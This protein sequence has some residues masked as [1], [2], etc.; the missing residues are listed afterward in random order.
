M[1][2]EDGCH[3]R[4]DT[5]MP[6]T[7]LKG[8]EGRGIRFITTICYN[9]LPVFRNEQAAGLVTKQLGETASI[10]G[11][12]IAAYVVMPTHMHGLFGF[13]DVK[14]MPEFML[15]FKSLSSR[16]IKELNPLVF[17]E[18]L[19]KSET[20]H[21]WKKRYDD[22]IIYSKEQ[23]KTKLDYIHNNPVKAELVKSA[24]DWRYSSARDWLSGEPGLIPI[25]KC[26]TWLK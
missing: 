23:F 3:A 17:G 9:W 15:N 2:P 22:V 5:I 24:I 4:D 6:T 16:L 13:P 7:R 8:L 18:P 14:A 20:Y 11:I 25:D 21:L 26:L 19:N 1:A 12:S 10:M